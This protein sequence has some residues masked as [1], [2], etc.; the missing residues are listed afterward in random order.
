MSEVEEPVFA[1]AN[2]TPDS[3]RVDCPTCGGPLSV[4]EVEDDDAG[5][6]FGA[7]ENCV[8]VCDQCSTTIAVKGCKVI[9]TDEAPWFNRSPS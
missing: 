1:E 9:P 6:W 4:D 5:V 7:R 8:V 3:W 2:L